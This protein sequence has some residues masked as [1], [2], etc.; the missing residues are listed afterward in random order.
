M[1]VKVLI[2]CEV[3]G[4]FDVEACLCAH[5]IVRKVGFFHFGFYAVLAHLSTVFKVSFVSKQHQDG[6]FLFVVVR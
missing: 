3:E 2:A 6:L 5:F 4:F 1:I